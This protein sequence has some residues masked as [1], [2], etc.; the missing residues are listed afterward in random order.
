VAK[1]GTAGQS[2]DDNIIRRMR[3][4][5]WVT[6]TRIHTHTQY[7][8]LTTFPQQ[9]WLRERAPTLRYTYCTLPALFHFN[10]RQ[11]T[12]QK[13]LERSTPGGCRPTMR[14]SLSA[15]GDDQMGNL[16]SGQN[17]LPTDSVQRSSRGPQI[18][19][20]STSHLKI[21]GTRRVT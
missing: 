12:P 4:A 15:Q 2:T 5:C 9:Q 18:Y 17:C 10:S 11:L 1:Y 16:P 19:R 7:I 14:R 20:K 21:L 3:F 6:K 8:L 13:N